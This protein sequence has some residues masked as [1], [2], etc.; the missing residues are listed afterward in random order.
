MQAT[1]IQFSQSSTT[2][3]FEAAFQDLESI[4]D[5]KNS[6]LLTDETVFAAHKNVFDGWTT[7]VIKGGEAHKDQA[8]VD[9]IIQQ[10]IAHGA[11]RTTML[12]GVGG[13]V[14]TDIT[15]YVA[16]VYLRGIS[17]CFVPTTILAMVDAA[18]GGKNGVDVGLYK[19]MVG[20]INQPKFL[21]YDMGFL[22]SLPIKEWRNGFAEIIKHAAIKRADL[23]EQLA[24]KSIEW[25]QKDETDLQNLVRENVLLKAGV[26]QRDERE[27]GERRLL[28][29]GHTL[30]HALEKKYDLM[31]GEA[32]AIGMVFAANLSAA[33][34]G[35][36]KVDQ[37]KNLIQQYGLPTEMSY[38]SEMVFDMLQ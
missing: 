32:V 3:Y 2:F 27:S 13:G 36:E 23:F 17:F 29:F 19:N 35:F 24:N 26:V 31:H 21:L 38:D 33:L 4:V 37:L 7:L 10:L 30:A 8:T 15:G 9:Y 6:I 18:I 16:S 20:T 22:K 25:Y 12:I 14:V 1:E 34:C 5:K 11:D 28:N